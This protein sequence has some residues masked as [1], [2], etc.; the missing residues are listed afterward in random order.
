MKKPRY[1]ALFCFC[2]A[3]TLQRIR[4]QV[5]Y[6]SGVFPNGFSVVKNTALYVW[7]EFDGVM[8]HAAGA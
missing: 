3:P 8:A 4:L 6:F 7:I 5:F 1:G 2:A